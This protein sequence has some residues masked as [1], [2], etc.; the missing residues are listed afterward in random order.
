MGNGSSGCRK[1]C[2]SWWLWQVCVKGGYGGF[3]WR[4]LVF[5]FWGGGAGLFLIGWLGVVGLVTLLVEGLG[6]GGGGGVIGQ[7]LGLVCGWGQVG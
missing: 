3:E 2:G 4:S 6:L 1:E 5:C 7:L